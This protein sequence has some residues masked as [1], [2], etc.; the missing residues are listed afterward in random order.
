LSDRGFEAVVRTAFL[1]R[2]RWSTEVVVN[3]GVALF[4]LATLAASMLQSLAALCAVMVVAGSSWIIFLSLFSVLVLNHAPE[5]VRA[6]VLAFSTLAFQGAIAAGSAAWGAVALRLGVG[7]TLLYAG[8]GTLTMTA[9]ALFL[10]LPDGT[11]LE[12]L[13]R[14]GTLPGSW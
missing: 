10:R 11:G 9:L 12:I 14:H 8:A 3:G 2:E 1:A 6:C 5:W 13:D 7:V 4:G